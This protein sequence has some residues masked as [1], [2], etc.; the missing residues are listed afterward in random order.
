ME[1]TVGKMGATEEKP[2]TSHRFG[3]FFFWDEAEF[4]KG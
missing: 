3:N 2:R 4:G 1:I